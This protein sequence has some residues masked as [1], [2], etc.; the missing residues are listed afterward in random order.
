[1]LATIP[2]KGRFRLVGSRYR[3]GIGP[4]R[5]RRKVSDH[6]LVSPRAQRVELTLRLSWEGAPSKKYFSKVTKKRVG[7][8][9]KH[10]LQGGGELSRSRHRLLFRR[11]RSSSRLF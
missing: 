4:S 2:C 6:I 5:S 3:E 9:T 11:E 1:M 10:Y 8:A 7:A